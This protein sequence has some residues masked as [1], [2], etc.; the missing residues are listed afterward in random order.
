MRNLG[1]FKKYVII[2]LLSF[3]TFYAKGQQDPMFTQYMFNIQSVNPAYAGMWERLGFMSMVR[4]QWAGI[5]KSPITELVSFHSPIKNEFVGVGLN[6]TY[7]KI[8]YEKKLSIFADYSYKLLLSNKLSLRLG[9]KFGVTNYNNNLEQYQLYPDGI[10]DP[11]FQGEIDLKFMPNFGVGGFLFTDDWYISLST[12]K[13]IKNDFAANINNY[14]SVA[15][16]RHFYLIAGYVF[17]L[18]QNI[19]FKPTMLVKA[20]F[21]APLQ[22]DIGANF[23]LK[24]R[25]ELGVMYRTGD[26]IAAL[27]QWKITKNLTIGY[28]SDFTLTEIRQ[29]QNGTYEF[30]VSYDI[31][32]YRR[33][34][35]RNRYF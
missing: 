5:D 35:L 2:C 33:T 29:Y 18:P 23:H 30:Y 4:K 26:A 34:Y 20:A 19:K 32:F 21:G 31:D 7:D 22:A 17:D 8:G 9:L 6:A 13:L 1:P 3:A 12:P 15:E 28:A 24:D 11:A 10:Y 25:I 16:A 14:S 27:I